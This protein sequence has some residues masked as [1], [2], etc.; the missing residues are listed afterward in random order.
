MSR[1]KATLMLT[2]SILALALL[3]HGGASSMEAQTISNTSLLVVPDKAFFRPGEAATFSVTASAGEHVEGTV[4]HLTATVA[5]LEA[6]VVDGRATLTWQPPSDAPRGYG[7][8]VSVRDADHNTLAQASTAFDVLEHWLQ[9]PRYGFLSDFEPGRDNAAETMAWV[10]RYHVNGLQF[11][12]WQYRHETL[13]PPQD[14]YTDL[15]GKQMSLPVIRDLVH[16]AH[17]HNIAAMPYTAI[18]GAS[19]AFYEQHRDWALFQANDVPFD[20]ADR[21]LYIMDPSPGSPWAEHLLGEFASVLDQT[22]FDG[23][24]LDQYGAPKSGRNHAGEYVDLAEA[25]PAFIDEAAQIVRAKRGSNGAMIFNAVGNWPV[26]TVAPANQDAVYIEVWAPYRDF[27]DLHRIVANAEQ[28]G[29]GKPV[30]IAAYI[31]PNNTHNVRLANAMINASGAYHLELGEPHAMLADPY[32]PKYGAMDGTMQAIMQ[33]TYDF[34]VRY[35]E[36]LSVGTIDATPTRAAA[37]TIEGV[38]TQGLRA[39]DRVVVIVRQ[40]PLRETFNLVNFLGVRHSRW[41]EPLFDDGGPEPQRDL[42]V[43]L[44]VERPVAQVW[45]ASPDTAAQME[46][47]RVDFSVSADDAGT[48]I[49]FSVPHL[50][51]WT[52]IVVEYVA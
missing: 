17:A 12:D 8:T 26:E 28:L 20:F 2:G 5:M 51:Y 22:E 47:Q 34:L 11:Y 30:I 4:T 27:L 24:H 35:E 46:P 42:P 9:A 36:V 43:R 49:A 41:E 18:Y 38:D 19:P 23:V 48:V 33:R 10:A 52:M 7:L 37:L 50:D 32:F 6:D 14:L 44:R 40:G 15:L 39:R 3:F 25:F 21:Y 29:G 1:S 13:M 45:L 31:H 16:A